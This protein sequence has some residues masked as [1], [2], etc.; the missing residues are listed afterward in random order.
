MHRSRFRLAA[1]AALT[2]ALALTTSSSLS[3]ARAQQ[4]GATPT[5]TSAG[6]RSDRL[7]GATLADTGSRKTGKISPVLDK[8]YRVDLL[9]RV[10]KGQPLT[11]AGARAIGDDIAGLL[12]A[13]KLQIAPDDR[14]Q[15]WLSS[16]GAAAGIAGPLAALGAS[17]QV[18][19]NTNRIV[20]AL[21]PLSQLQAAST[22]AGVQTV[23][24]PVYGSVQTG[25]KLTEGDSILGSATLRSQLTAADGAGVRIGVV[26]DGVAGLAASQA[27]ADVGAVDTTTC[28]RSPGATSPTAPNAGPEGTAILEIIHDIAPAAQLSFGYFG[29]NTGGTALNFNA[30]VTCLAQNN[31][32]V[33]DDV[34]FFNAG[35][36]DG[37]SI[38]SANTNAALNNP[39]YPIRGYYTSAGNQAQQHYREAFASSGD[40]VSNANGSWTLQRFQ[41]TANTTDLGGTLTCASGGSGSCGDLIELQPGGTVEVDLSW[42]DPYGASRNDYDLLVFD[43]LDGPN[44]TIRVISG[45]TQSG[46][47]DPTESAVIQNTHAVNESLYVMIG[48][49]QGA[50]APVTFD[51]FMNCLRGCFQLTNAGR[52]V[53]SLANF[54]TTPG[55][56]PNQSDSA[57]GVLAVGAIAASDPG[58]DTIESY[59][60]R[61]P[62][63]D[64]RNKPDISG[65][66]CV[67]VT[68][69]GGFY[70]PFCGTSAAAPHVAAIAA[71]MLSCNPT[72]LAGKAQSVA[73]TTARTTLR[74]ALLNGA[75]P[76]GVGQP[77]TTYGFGRV[78]AVNAAPLANCK[79][80]DG[81]GYPDGLETTLG[82]NPAS[83]C[84]IMR[85]DINGDRSVNGL[86]LAALGTNFVKTVP[87]A[88]PRVD[89]NADGAIDG[90][91]LTRLANVFLET[92]S[93]CP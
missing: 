16:T 35:P 57:G 25:S 51:M 84:P 33:V 92:V 10:A 52:T 22:I 40:V 6:G 61:G 37:T 89:Q 24:L 55:S 11:A 8:L 23:Q 3:P 43:L 50:A 77:N 82:K 14:V 64:N 20:Q 78:N 63:A 53:F 18:I 66:D 90:I 17:V 15:V 80:T 87:P 91:D 4:P 44:G 2:L 34:S 86:D 21:V 54:N 67:Q 31:D 76:L 28:N 71:L 68:G 72:L 36:Y 9:N 79:D 85:A 58:N 75:T 27:S 73:T 41:A 29:I 12:Q 65:I 5:A 7:Q 69:N 30:A 48:N 74:N 88:P 60:S 70:N 26:S 1:A 39:A 49:Y 42:N 62:T 46:S 19:D 38:V 47:Q 93:Q 13:Q 83:A 45:N 32:I 59:S 56:V 81:D